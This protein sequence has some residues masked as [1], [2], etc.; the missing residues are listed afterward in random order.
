MKEK[1]RRGRGGEGE[2]VADN[3]GV[4]LSRE[5]GRRWWGGGS[6]ID[7]VEQVQGEEKAIVGG[8]MGV[9]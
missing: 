3:R 9:D 1:G 4:A 7:V 8:C 5:Q 2:R 6:W